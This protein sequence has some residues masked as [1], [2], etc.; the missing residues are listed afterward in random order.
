MDVKIE[1][2]GMIP[3]GTSYGLSAGH[4]CEWWGDS[5]EEVEITQQNTPVPSGTR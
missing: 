3:T 4:R 2:T 1:P 5:D